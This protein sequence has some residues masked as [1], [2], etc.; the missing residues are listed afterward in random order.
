MAAA[1]AAAAVAVGG[2]GGGRSR[3]NPQSNGIWRSLDKGKTW[4]V[5]VSNENQ[6]PMYFSQIRVDPNNPDIVYV[7]GVNPQKSIDGGK[8]FTPIQRHGSRRQPRDLD[9]SAA[10][11]G[12]QQ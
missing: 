7:G 8:T 11:A 12:K 3:P 9:R 6:R 1:V 5:P 4:D 2:R 10:T